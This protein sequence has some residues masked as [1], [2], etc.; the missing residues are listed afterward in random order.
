MVL[1]ES[2]VSLSSLME[3]HRLG[4]ADGIT[5]KLTRVGGITPA[6]TIRDAA[7]EL[8]IGVTIE[9]ASGCDL[10]DTTFAHLNASTPERLRVHTVDFDS[11]AT[12]TY[13][14]GPSPRVRLVTTASA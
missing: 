11:W 2:I 5:V 10:A 3:A 1:D 9:D 13:V 6:T 8:G 4:V 12:L 14:D 7:V